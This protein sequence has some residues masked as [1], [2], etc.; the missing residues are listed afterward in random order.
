MVKQNGILGETR[1]VSE[2]PF[3]T[4]SCKMLAAYITAM[5]YA[6]AGRR[7]KGLWCGEQERK[8]YAAIDEWRRRTEHT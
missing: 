4:W 6:I 2:P 5:E 3:S 8:M 7:A 1:D